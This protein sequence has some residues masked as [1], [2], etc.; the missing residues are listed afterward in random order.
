MFKRGCDFSIPIFFFTKKPKTSSYK[1]PF[2]CRRDG[3]IAV[4]PSGELLFC[5]LGTGEYNELAGESLPCS[6]FV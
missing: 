6:F 1:R 2:A 4:V 5:G 3:R